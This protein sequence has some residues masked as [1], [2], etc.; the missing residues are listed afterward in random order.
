VNQMQRRDLLSLLAAAAATPVGGE[1]LVWSAGL[2]RISTAA[3]NGFEDITTV[4]ASK[5]NTSSPHILLGSVTGHLE[6]VTAALKNSVME[7]N[8][9]QRLESI[10]ADVSLFVGALSMHSGKLAQ[11]DAHL[12]L[13]ERMANQ[14]GNMT[15]L[16]GTYA[17]QALLHYYS[18]APG[19]QHDNPK[20]RI[21]LLEQADQLAGRY[22][23]A[24]IQMAT[25]AW[26][27][28]DKALAKDGYGADQALE[29]SRSA[30]HKAQIEGA[31]GSGFTSSA[32]HFSGWD[33]DRFEGLRGGVEVSLG[34]KTAIDTI[35]TSLRFK[36]Q[37]RWRASGLVDLAIALIA[38]K[39][40]EETCARLIEAH[41]I[42][43]SQGSAT[44]LHHV[45]S[46]RAQMPRTWNSLRC[47]REL[48][49]RLRVG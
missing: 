8:H 17:Q 9:R 11:A 22:A 35:T 5:Y 20:D 13:A 28:E 33:E 15:L 42:G 6:G 19:G 49:E 25:S 16:A 39:Q 43:R 44:I 24:I 27:A 34:R 14:A 2:P 41:T 32:G 45:F 21:E 23:P 48:D 7:P 29:R 10:V 46:A 30:L 12:E 18:Q 36:T 31:V 3:L 26:L 47:V 40:P 38:H 1:S 37:P 4:L